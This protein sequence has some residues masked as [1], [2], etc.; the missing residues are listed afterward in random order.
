MRSTLKP[1]NRTLFLPT[2]VVILLVTGTDGQGRQ[3]G[4]GGVP[5]EQYGTAF[6]TDNPDLTAF[7]DRGGKAIVWRGWADQFI[8]AEGSIDYYTRVQQ[9]MGGP[10]KAAEFMRLFMAPGVMYYTGGAGPQPT[11]Q[12][13]AIL[14]WVEDGKAPDAL[15][16]T[17][18]DQSGAATRSRPVCAY[19]LVAKYKGS[20]SP[21]DASNFSCSTGF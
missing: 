3:G 15:I 10:K 19:P 20:G 16:A 13:E 14:A 11:G 1:V 8:T 12:L 5:V 9:E 4:R 18:R 6:G 17:R 21:D 2:A 7:R